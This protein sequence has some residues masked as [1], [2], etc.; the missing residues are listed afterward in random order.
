MLLVEPVMES[1][2]WQALLPGEVFQGQ[3]AGAVT[4]N[5]CGDLLETLNRMM[6]AIMFHPPILPVLLALHRMCPPYRLRL[7]VRI[8]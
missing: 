5:D 2:R 4:G 8:G 6:V 3:S 1:P 7:F